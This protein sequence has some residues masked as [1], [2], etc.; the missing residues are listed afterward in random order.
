MRALLW[1]VTAVIIGAVVFLSALERQRD[2]AIL[3]AM[4]TPR[5]ALL[6]AVAAQAVLIAIAAAVVAMV[7]QRLIVPM[8][9]LRVRV[10]GRALWQ[11]PV[12]AV[13]AALLAGA[14]GLRRVAST[15][16]ASAFSGPGG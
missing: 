6:L 9:P 13:V 4:G 2:F 8:F 14:A 11:I 16:P 10:P 5:R 7:L 1:V 15:D 3:R 12:G